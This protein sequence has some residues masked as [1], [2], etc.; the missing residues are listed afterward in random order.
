MRLLSFF[1]LESHYM[2]EG[3]I[4]LSPD[5]LVYQGAGL[6]VFDSIYELFNSGDTWTVE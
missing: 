6:I 4:V 3:Q 5:R 1:V 2:E